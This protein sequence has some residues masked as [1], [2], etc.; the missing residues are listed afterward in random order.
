[1]VLDSGKVV[2]HA[3]PAELMAQPESHLSRLV[4]ATGEESAAELRA[5]ADKKLRSKGTVA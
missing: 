2:E 1:M 3:T 5:M 4:D